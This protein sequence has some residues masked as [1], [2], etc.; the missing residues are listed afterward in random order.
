MIKATCRRYGF[1]MIINY[2]RKVIG[3]TGTGH[4]SPIG[5]YN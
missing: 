5:G 1:Y 2:D 4:F 3:Q